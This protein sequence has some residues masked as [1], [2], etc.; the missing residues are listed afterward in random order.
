MGANPDANGGILLRE[1]RLP[2]FHDYAVHVPAP[3]AVEAEATRVQG[4]FMPYVM[5]LNA[6]GRNFRVFSPDE[7]A[8][9]RWNAGFEVTTRCSTA[10]IS[11]LDDH[12]S[13]DGRVI[14]VLSEH[15]CQGRKCLSRIGKGPFPPCG[16]RSGWGEERA[17]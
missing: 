2:D 12:V 17:S 15:L 11:P 7:A 1:L 5:K 3:G 16:G 6:E 10:E 8:S 9:N 13:P 4:A 14:E